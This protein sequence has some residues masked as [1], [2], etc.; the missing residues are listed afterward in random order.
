L[1]LTPKNIFL[2]N[3]KAGFIL[4]STLNKSIYWFGYNNTV[5]VEKLHRISIKLPTKNGE[6]DFDFMENFIWAIQKLVIADVVEY[7]REKIGV[8]REIVEWKV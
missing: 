8:T 4:A 1:V 5:S 7:A 3:R 6:I 2:K